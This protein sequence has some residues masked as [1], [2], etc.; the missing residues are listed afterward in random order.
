[1]QSLKQE[2]DKIQQVVWQRKDQ[3][4]KQRLMKKKKSKVIAMHQMSYNK[5]SGKMTSQEEI[6]IAE[7]KRLQAADENSMDAVERR[8][9][10]AE[11]EQKV[12]EDQ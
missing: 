3:Q 7:L 11:L 1:M 9:Q 12:R 5:H 6:P 2:K 8:R 10:R 4:L